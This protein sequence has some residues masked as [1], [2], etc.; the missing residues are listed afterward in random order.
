MVPMTYYVA[1]TFRRSEQNGGIVAW[2]N[3]LARRTRREDS[4]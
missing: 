3:G 4:S 2:L 1:L